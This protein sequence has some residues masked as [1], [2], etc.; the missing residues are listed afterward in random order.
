M[1]VPLIAWRTSRRYTKDIVYVLSLPA[2]MDKLQERI[3]LKLAVNSITPDMLQR[4]WTKLDYS[5]DECRGT[6]EAHIKYL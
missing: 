4:V 6:R 3:I 5:F 1:H 2:T